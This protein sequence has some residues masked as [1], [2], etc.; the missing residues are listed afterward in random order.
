MEKT[1]EKKIDGAVIGRIIADKMLECAR[2]AKD[3]GEGS[4]TMNLHRAMAGTALA[5][6]QQAT[7]NK[8]SG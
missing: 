6:G 8:Q 1:E 5:A 4:Y 7:G 2:A 3:R